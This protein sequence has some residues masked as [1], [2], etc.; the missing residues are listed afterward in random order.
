MVK[1]IAIAALLSV[2][3][4]APVVAHA[5]VPSAAGPAARIQM[6]L[7]LDRLRIA[8]GVRFGQITRGELEALQGEAQAIRSHLQAIRQTGAPPTAAD[9]QAL[10]QELRRFS[11]SIYAA[12]HHGVGAGS[13]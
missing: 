5:R 10:R 11:Q 3:M 9:R 6:L 8:Q 1:H 4:A 12:R 2:G 7:R 13:D